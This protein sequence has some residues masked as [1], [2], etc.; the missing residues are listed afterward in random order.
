[1][2]SQ[3]TLRPNPGSK[4]EKR[5]LGRGDSSGHGSF[6]GR[7]GKGQTARS[8]G[9][10]HPRFE[11]GQTP[12][13]RRLPKLKGFKNFNKV[14]YQA[15]NVDRLNSFDDDSTVD[16]VALFEKNIISRKNLPVKLLASGDL[17]KKLTVK[18]DACSKEA[19]K[20]V[21]AKGGTIIIPKNV[22]KI[23]EKA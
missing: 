9:R 2:I 4:K 7:G 17:N 14:P 8:G 15:V 22:P 12:L 23:Q 21:E 5:G 13:I 16:I 19:R 1:M 11:G 6:S 3:H 18:V 10:L 20:K